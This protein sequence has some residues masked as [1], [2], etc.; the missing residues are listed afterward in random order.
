[1]HQ[2]EWQQSKSLQRTFVRSIKYSGGQCRCC[3]CV[4][5]WLTQHLIYAIFRACTKSTSVRVCV[6]CGEVPDVAIC[7][8]DKVNN[9]SVWRSLV[10]IS[11]KRLASIPAHTKNNNRNQRTS[12]AVFLINVKHLLNVILILWQYTVQMLRIDSRKFVHI[13]DTI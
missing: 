13:N 3:F 10:C 1:M 8:Y 4:T 6:C 5:G 12:Q 11:S 7:M 9:M 2:S